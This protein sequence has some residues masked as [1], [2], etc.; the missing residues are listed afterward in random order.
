[1]NVMQYGKDV[2]PVQPRL[3]HRVRAFTLIELLVVIAIIAI[4]AAMLLPALAKAKDKANQIKCLS[5]LRQLSTSAI[6]YQTDTGRSLE[7]NATA[8]LWMKTLSDYSI[9]VKENRFCPVAS[10]RTPP[11]PDPVAGTAAAPWYWTPAGDTNMQ[12]SYAINGWLYY[13]DAKA[14][15]ISQWVTVA[16]RPKFFQKD[17]DIRSPSLTPFFVDAIWP[18]TW[19]VITDLP[20]V[21][22]FLGDVNS[23]LGRVCIARHPL[24]RNARAVSGQRLSGSIDMS[25]ADGHA[26]K[27]PLQQIKTVLWH[28]GYR[29]TGDPWRQAP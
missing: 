7:Y 16:D 11:P 14:G 28:Q 20:P 1:M 21:N 9:K 3:W 26:A 10:S 17:T 24:N 5:N 6:L 18:D 22:L 13:W 27:L 4:L 8:Q 25:F 19:P 23:S 15:G 2:V 12:G 29:A